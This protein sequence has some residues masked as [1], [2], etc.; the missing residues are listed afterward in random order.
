MAPPLSLENTQ[1]AVL[2]VVAAARRTTSTPTSI[3]P[4]ITTRRMDRP[5]LLLH[6]A[7]TFTLQRTLSRS[8]T[9]DET[10]G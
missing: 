1:L 9:K 10:D 5:L 2:P 7:T 8:T 3:M 6:K 4:T